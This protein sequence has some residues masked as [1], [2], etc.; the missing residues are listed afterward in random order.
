MHLW[1]L[2]LVRNRCYLLTLLGD[3]QSDNSINP[4]IASNYARIIRGNLKVIL[5]MPLL[6]TSALDG[7]SPA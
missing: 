5:T 3:V 7:Q 4:S 2:L 1:I 6:I